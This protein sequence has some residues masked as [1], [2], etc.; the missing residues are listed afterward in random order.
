VRLVDRDEPRAACC[1]SRR[2]A[3]PLADI[4]SGERTRAGSGVATLATP[5]A[6]VRR[7]AVQ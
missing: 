6:L 3:A 4:R 5:V 1:S 2:S 7:A